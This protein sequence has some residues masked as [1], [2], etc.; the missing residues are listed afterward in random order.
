MINIIISFSEGRVV[1]DLFYNSFPELLHQYGLNLEVFTP[2]QRVPEFTQRWEQPGVRFYPLP[3]CSLS[4]SEYR[5]LAIRAR[6][7]QSAPRLLDLW[8]RIERAQYNQ[9]DPAIVGVFRRENPSLLVITN[10]MQHH[11]L[12]VFRAAQSL[13]IPTLGVIR[14]WD[15]L[16]KGLRLRPD[17]LAVWNPINRE[18]AIRLMKYPPERVEMIGAT[19]FDPYFD[20]AGVCTRQEFAAGLGLD[21]ARPIIT[22]ATLGAF[23]HQYD[24]TY[25]MDWLMDAIRA[26]ELP[27]EAQ[28]ICRLHPASRLEQFL[29][30][31]AYPNVRL[32]FIDKFIPSLGWTMTRE[33][34]FFVAN[35]LR[36]SDVVISP[37]ST[38]TIET[39]IF[40]TPTIV[41]IFHTYQPEAG[42]L[43]FNQHLATH[44]RRLKELDLVPIVDTPEALAEAT[45][46]A[47]ADRSW[48]R[49]QRKQLV[50]DY[51]YF[52]D[53]KSTE[54]LV[55]LIN[56]LST[57]QSRG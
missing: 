45:R 51:I 54:R 19:Q 17:V 47:L 33:D 25:L 8:L 7:I 21:P 3:P 41:P 16:Y 14:S 46:R 20:P 15:N 48:Y 5:A 27:P 29:K 11:E 52:T 1:R 10:P 50:D 12:P 32:S 9:P 34:V 57:I 39:A 13:G 6:I 56:R 35:L 18:E 36:H 31:Q 26:G 23:Q 2:A 55:D 40:D 24:E 38:I 44:F 4:K 28:V 22:L 53:G 30:Y 37:G 49:A 42:K 43:Q